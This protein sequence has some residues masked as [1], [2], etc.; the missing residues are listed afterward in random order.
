MII[1]TTI[2]SFTAPLWFAYQPVT[3][4]NETKTIHGSEESAARRRIHN[5]DQR[6]KDTDIEYLGGAA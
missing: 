3:Y 5:T 2:R 1:Q 6:K 4:R